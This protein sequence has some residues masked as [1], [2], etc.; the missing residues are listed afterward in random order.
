MSARP[1]R[2]PPPRHSELELRQIHQSRKNESDSELLTLNDG[3]L[4]RRLRRWG[5]CGRC[6]AAATRVGCPSTVAAG[7]RL[8][9][10]EPRRA[11]V[12]NLLTGLCGVPRVARPRGAPPRLPGCAGG[13]LTESPHGTGCRSHGF[14]ARRPASSSPR[15]GASGGGRAVRLA[16]PV[17]AACCGGLPRRA[18]P[19]RRVSPDSAWTTLLRIPHFGWRTVAAA[20]HA[21]WFRAMPAKSKSRL[22]LHLAFARA[23]GAASSPG[24]LV[25]A[26][27]ASV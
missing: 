7:G 25:D 5:G 14:S 22:V 21:P 13:C 1:S 23:L 26:T 17:E 20:R 10:P 12:G 2:C 15:L 9:A 11:A 4:S 16:R 19:P 24:D 8:C 3:G 18:C 27:S 6:A